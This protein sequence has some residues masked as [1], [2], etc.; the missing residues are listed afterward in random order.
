M[1]SSSGDKTI[2]LWD[3]VNGAVLKTLSGHTGDVTFLA[4]LSDSILISGSYR[5]IIFW[6]IVNENVI[7]TYF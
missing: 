4:E 2:I 1:A 3:T 5:T 7:K 6:D